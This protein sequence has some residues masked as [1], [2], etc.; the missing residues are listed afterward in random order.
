MRKW[1]IKLV[2]VGPDG[3]ELPAAFIDKVTYNLHP[4]FAKPTRRISPESRI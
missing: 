3:S 2:A 4:S 1:S